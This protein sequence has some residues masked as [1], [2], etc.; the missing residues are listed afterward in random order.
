[1]EE[2]PFQLSSL[3]RSGLYC[4]SLGIDSDDDARATSPALDVNRQ[5]AWDV[6]AVEYLLTFAEIQAAYEMNGVCD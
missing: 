4:N 6:R 1:M 2:P 5:E 3:Q